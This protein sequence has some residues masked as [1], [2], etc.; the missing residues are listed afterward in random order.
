M[1]ELDLLISEIDKLNMENIKAYNLSNRNPLFDYVL[2]ASATNDRQANAIIKNLRE[3][4]TKGEISI[5]GI[6]DKDLSWILIDLDDI[7][8]HIFSSD[9][10]AYYGLDEIYNEYLMENKNV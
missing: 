10:R 6:E 3:L 5:R 1:K 7:I 4:E 8:V 2:I 9:K